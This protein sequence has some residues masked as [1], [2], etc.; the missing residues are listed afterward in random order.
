MQLLC[1]F[2]SDKALV[3]FKDFIIKLMVN[4]HMDAKLHTYLSDLE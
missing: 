2:D 3:S 1:C 4:G